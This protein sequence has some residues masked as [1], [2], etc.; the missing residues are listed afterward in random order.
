V[1]SNV[2]ASITVEGSARCSERPLP[3]E[4]C[5]L[6]ARTYHVHVYGDDPR[7]DQSFTVAVE[8]G[9]VRRELRFGVVEALPGY[10][11]AYGEADAPSPRLAVLPGTHDLVLVDE[12]HGARQRLTIPVEHDQRSFVP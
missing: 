6:A 2:P 10:G 1:T 3:L 8:G 9:E 7:L 4:R 11:L 12:A 5:P